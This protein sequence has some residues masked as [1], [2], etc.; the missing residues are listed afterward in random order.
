MVKPGSWVIDSSCG[1]TVRRFVEP[2]DPSPWW[3]GLA[4]AFFLATCFALLIVDTVRAKQAEADRI[5][6]FIKNR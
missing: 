6:E 3:L 2:E 5:T 4:W 1:I